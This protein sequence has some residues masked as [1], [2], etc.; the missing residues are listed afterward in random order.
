MGPVSRRNGS[1]SVLRSASVEL[2]VVRGTA[3]GKAMDA[4]LLGKE[5]RLAGNSRGGCLQLGRCC[6]GRRGFWLGNG[7][8][9]LLLGNVIGGRQLSGLD[10]CNV[11]LLLGDYGYLPVVP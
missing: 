9:V 8:L 3:L 6:R 11:R 1:A 4:R 2:V 5:V 10:D 7:C